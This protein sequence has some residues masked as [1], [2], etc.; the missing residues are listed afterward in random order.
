MPVY[1]YLAP[2][3]FDVLREA[4]IRFTQPNALNDP[5]ELKPFFKTIFNMDTF[6][7]K[8]RQKMDFRPALLEKYEKMPREIRNKFTP[9]QFVQLAIS[10]M[11]QNKDQYDAM[12]N[13]NIDEMSAVMPALTEKLRSLLHGHLG[14]EVGILSLSE[15]PVNDLMWAHYANH[16]TGFVIEFDGANEFFHR[17]RSYED[18]FFHLRQV[19][20]IDKRLNF[21][22]FE[23]LVD[24]END[25]L[26]SKL[27]SWAYEKEWRM[28]VPLL[29]RVPEIDAVE[30][31][32]LFPFPREAVR[33]VI[34]GYRSSAEIRNEVST[35]LGSD[36]AYIDVHRFVASIDLEH[37]EIATE[38]YS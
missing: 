4:R 14:S 1:K 34:F 26:A 36:A 30:P 27:N 28:L 18:E 12:F 21:E 22:S 37:G 33:S 20:Y 24:D 8:I 3:R 23:Q 6:R 16:H 32:H 10:H 25:L 19:S 31:I 11:E 15:D 38:P 17:Q 2:E 5:F 13:S 29:N 9:D 7:N 35:I